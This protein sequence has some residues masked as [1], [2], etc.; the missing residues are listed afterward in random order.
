MYEI[1]WGIGG[2]A[3]AVFC[4]GS[5]VFAVAMGLCSTIWFWLSLFGGPSFYAM[6]LS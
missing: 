2:F 5:A 3:L 1:A 4:L 6:C